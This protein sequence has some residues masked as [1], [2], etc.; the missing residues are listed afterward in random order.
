MSCINPRQAELI[1]EREGP[2]SQA[3]SEHLQDCETCRDLEQRFS[4]AQELDEAVHPSA[5]A[6]VAWDEDPESLDPG[7]QQW[8]RG[9][10][11]ECS[12]CREALEAIPHEA[13]NPRP[14]LRILGRQQLLAAAAVLLIAAA[15]WQFFDSGSAPAPPV[16]LLTLPA[17]T[18]VLSTLRGAPPPKS[19]SGSSPVIRFQP[20]LDEE[21]AIGQ[22]LRLHIQDEKGAPLVDEDMVVRLLDEDWG[23]P[24]LPVER[25][26][27]RRGRLTI[28]ITTPSGRSER[29][30]YDHR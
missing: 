25:A 6:L 23:R 13:H 20:T 22:H 17:T 16:D 1:L 12:L 7:V 28:S 21:I 9:H 24:I 15:G 2:R 30:V 18:V 5:E 14:W 19:V 27:L 29:F 10:L 8:M 4:Q 3:W 26:K 11:E